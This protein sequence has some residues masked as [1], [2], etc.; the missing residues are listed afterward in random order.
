MVPPVARGRRLLGALSVPTLDIAVTPGGIGAALPPVVVVVDVLR[1]TTMIAALLDAGGVGV[2]PVST[3]EEA[4][5]LQHDDPGLLLAGERGGVA[6]EGFDLG[7]SP[8]RVR[9]GLVAGRTVVLATTNGTPAL[10]SV[11]GAGVCLTLSLTNLGAVARRLTVL[12]RDAL[13]V[14]SG[15]DGGRSDEDELCAG[16][17]ADRL[18]AWARTDRADEAADQATGSIGASGGI[19]AAV[20]RSRHAARL[21]KLGFEDDVRM[22]ARLDTTPTVPVWDRVNG[23]LTPG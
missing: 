20:R 10:E 6:P 18:R 21:I 22:C 4:R 2:R 7:N 3:V 14:C 16:V 9:P 5:R 15:T 23:L 19:G 1:A 11:R 8:S 12:N 17:L 13:V